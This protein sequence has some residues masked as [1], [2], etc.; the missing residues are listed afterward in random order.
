MSAVEHTCALILA[1]AR[2]DHYTIIIIIIIVTDWPTYQ[3]AVALRPQIY[4]AHSSFL[5]TY[6][7]LQDI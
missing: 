2:C 1:V 7:N 4:S 5:D 3:L 6:L